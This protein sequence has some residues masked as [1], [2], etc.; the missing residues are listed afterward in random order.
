MS[1]ETLQQRIDAFLV[2][3]AKKAPPEALN[4][5]LGE[6]KKL[7]DSGAAKSALG[8]GASAPDFELRDSNGRVHAL[9]SLLAKGPVVVKFNRG[10]WCP[11]CDLELQ[12][13]SAALKN[14]GSVSASTVVLMPQAP[15]KIKEAIQG[16]NFAFDVLVDEGS[17]IA[18]K[19][20]V[21]FTLP[22]PLRPIYSSFGMNV[23]EWNG[24]KT[25]QLPFPSTFVIDRNGKISYAMVE[26]NWTKRPEPGE[27]IEKLKEA[28]K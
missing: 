23:S 18:K 22:E 4:T 17:Q 6:I 20:G 11:F 12:A 16:K 21:V 10:T 5:I 8:V 24:D 27:V 13:T 7:E 28:L 25:W 15:Q 19:F 3:L 14:L 1:S 26:A 2:E 9:K